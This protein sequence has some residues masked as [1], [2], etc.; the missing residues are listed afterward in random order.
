MVAME[1]QEQNNKSITNSKFHLR[2]LRT[3]KQMKVKITKL[4]EKL[5]DNQVLIMRSLKNT[6][7]YSTKEIMH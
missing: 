1:S 5:R 4:L 6:Q 3:R 2:G 7:V